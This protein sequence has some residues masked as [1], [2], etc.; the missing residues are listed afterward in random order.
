MCV[1]PNRRM[2]LSHT[3]AYCTHT[4]KEIVD[5]R[6]P[7]LVCTGTHTNSTSCTPDRPVKTLWNIQQA[8]LL[9]P[10]SAISSRFVQICQ[11]FGTSCCLCT[12]WHQFRSSGLGG[13]VSLCVCVCSLVWLFSCL[14]ALTCLFNCVLA[15]QSFLSASCLQDFLN[16]QAGKVGQG[17][18]CLY[19]GCPSALT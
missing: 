14:S 16:C 7:A 11:N 3:S 13:N 17:T 8:L 18:V 15:S 4:K 19:S 9:L 6:R 10:V 5:V 2:I 12:C 1:N